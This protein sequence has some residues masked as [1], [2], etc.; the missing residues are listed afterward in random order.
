MCV[1]RNI[2]RNSRYRIAFVFN[3]QYLSHRRIVAKDLVSQALCQNYRARVIKGI[4]SRTLNYIEIKNS[5]EG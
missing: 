3:L 1:L 5:E 4:F 2:I